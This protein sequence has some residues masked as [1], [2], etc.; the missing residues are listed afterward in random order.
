MFGETGFRKAFMLER[1][2]GRSMVYPIAPIAECMKKG[3]VVWGQRSFCEKKK[4]V[5]H[6]NDADQGGA[7]GPCLL[8][9]SCKKFKLCAR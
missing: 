4:L 1:G 8:D 9:I 5:Q 2:V 6:R 3:R 7:V